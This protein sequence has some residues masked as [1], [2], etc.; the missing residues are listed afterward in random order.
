M[1]VHSELERTLHADRRRIGITE[2]SAAIECSP[3]RH[4]V[5][6]DQRDANP[7]VNQCDEYSPCIWIVGQRFPCVSQ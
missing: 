3:E 7:E 1:H 2:R 5:R 4:G 6:L